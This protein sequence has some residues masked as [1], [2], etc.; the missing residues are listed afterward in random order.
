MPVCPVAPGTL[1]T[2]SETPRSSDMILPAVRASKSAPPPGPHGTM[3]LIGWSGYLACARV[4]V[5]VMASANAMAQSDTTLLAT[6]IVPP[7][8]ADLHVQRM[9]LWLCRQPEDPR[10]K[11]HLM[12]LIVSKA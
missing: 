4:S 12:R 7:F 3:K 10:S 11:S 1:I 5:A 8:A 9:V 2:G 6:T